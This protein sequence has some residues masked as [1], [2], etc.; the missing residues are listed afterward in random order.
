MA[1]ILVIDDRES[2][3]QFLTTLLAYGG[4]QLHEA[5]DGSEGL[6]LARACRPDLII[7][8][9][10]MPTMD[11]Y[12]F[13]RQLR[14]DP[15]I[16]ATAIIFYTASFLEDAARKLAEACGVSRILTKPAEPEDI[17]A[18]VEQAL[19]TSRGAPAPVVA[20][21]FDREHL[22]LVT[23]KLSDKVNE[24]ESLN[25]A[26]E[27]TVQRRTVALAA[28]NEQLRGFNR[29]KDEF[30]AVVSHDLRSPLS[31]IEMLTGL[32]RARG[33][34]ASAAD[35]DRNMESIQEAARHLLALVNDLLDVA[36]IESGHT[37]LDLAILRVGDVVRDSARALSF[38]AQAKEI[39]LE[40]NAPLDGAMI[41][42][43]RLKLSQVFSNLVGNA[44]KFTP[45]EGKVSVCV[46]DTED[47]VRTRITDTG[48]GIPQEALASLFEKFNQRHTVG[49][50][51]ERG[52]GLGLS[53]VNRL[54]EL[55]GGRMEVTSEVGR[56]STFTVHLPRHPVSPNS[57]LP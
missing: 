40:I 3:R 20:E 22:L 56:G 51:G 45:S 27:A 7:S 48:A 53:I 8:D 30:L 50:A 9:I 5:V 39:T 26:L 42:A 37:T 17:L 33:S 54:V 49:T 6:A 25:E 31:G 13:A 29:M 1:N 52:T 34:A 11:G 2:N 38:N 55:H 44:I 15:E 12:E 46:E 43:D 18:A 47:G 28:A 4:H 14:A 32:L 57:L 19:G 21:T 35:F 24:L 36:K 16:A 10:V 23:N 41:E